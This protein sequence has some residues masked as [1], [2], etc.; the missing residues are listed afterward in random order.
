[1]PVSAALFSDDW[2][3]MNA[4]VEPDVD[5]DGLGDETQ[6]ACVGDCQPAAPAPVKKKCHKGKKLKHGKC[7]KKHHK[8]HKHHG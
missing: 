6:D 3:A 1:M 7:V 4:T 5:H 2:F 8:H